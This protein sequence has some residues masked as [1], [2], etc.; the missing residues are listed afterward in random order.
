ML[1][2]NIFQLDFQRP[3]PFI[4]HLIGFV[5]LTVPVFLYFYLAEKGKH[6]GTI[7]KR[8]LGIYAKTHAGQSNKN[9]LIRNIVKFLPWEIAHTGVHWIVFY[10]SQNIEPPI[11]IWFALI[12]PQV[13]VVVYMLSILISKGKTSIYDII[14]STNIAS[15]DN[16]DLNNRTVF[17]QK[18]HVV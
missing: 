8:I 9:I 10:S 6:H 15:P 7:G 13:L 16:Q 3:S 12:A 17:Q 18:N 14:A 4:R 11:W 5:T 2:Q 1:L